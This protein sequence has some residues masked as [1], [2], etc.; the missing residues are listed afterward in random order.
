MASPATDAGSPAAIPRLDF[1][2]V[3]VFLGEKNGKYPDGNQVIVSGSDTRAVFDTPLVANRIGPEF[4]SADLVVLGHVHEDHLAGLHRLPQAKV[5][6]PAADLAAARSWEA[7]GAA[8]GTREE[9]L[10]QMLEKFQR[11]FF[12]V[13]RPDAVGYADGAVWDLGQVRVEAIHMPG[14]TAGH[15]VLLVEPEGVAFLGDID[16]GSFG[17]YYG[18]LT[19]SLADFRRTIARVKDIPARVWV[20]FHHRAVYTDRERL[21]TDLAAYAAKIDEREKRLVE[22]LR[23]GPKTLADLV[24]CR[25]LYPADYQEL[26]VEDVEARTISQHLAELTANGRAQVDEAGLFRLG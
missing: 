3:S 6:A 11:E 4:D 5:Y 13:P 2:R 8:Y 23:A 19:S 22:L 21:L 12:Y 16:L 20:T 25:L 7:L 24:A 1:G 18:D 10:P 15:S 17:P 26:W 14:H 9:R